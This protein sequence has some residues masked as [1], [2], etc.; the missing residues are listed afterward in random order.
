MRQSAIILAAL[1][2]FAPAVGLADLQLMPRDASCV[3]EMTVQKRGCEVDIISR[4]D[5][6]FRTENYTA[7][8]FDF[9]TLETLA[10][11]PI[12]VGDPSGDF[13]VQFDPESTQ[14]TPPDQVIATGHGASRQTAVLSMMGL[15]K[16]LTAEG[17]ITLD[18]VTVRLGGIALR[19]FNVTLALSAP[20]PV[21]M[22]TADA[23][24]YY[25]SAR[26]LM[27]EG[28]AEGF[29]GSEEF[30]VPTA[31]A[32]IFLP[33]QVGF[34]DIIPKFDCGEISFAPA[35]DMDGKVG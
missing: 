8:G 3:P 4:C 29:F 34:G 28:E 30:D 24:Y 31:P 5:S 18:P 21:G 20:A 1:G 27:F 26:G 25:D 10:H 9:I 35:P 6:H 15:T 17:I 14:S 12:I 33:G 19:R 32:K 13:F 23:K 11:N 2:A 22:V 16:P 7:E